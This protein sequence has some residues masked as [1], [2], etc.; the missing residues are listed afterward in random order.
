MFKEERKRIDGLT[1]FVVQA[2]YC[3]MMIVLIFVVKT[4]IKI[5]ELEK[6]PGKEDSTV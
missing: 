4:L 2:K 5:S 1:G 6:L 3:S